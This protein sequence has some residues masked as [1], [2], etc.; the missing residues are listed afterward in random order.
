MFSKFWHREKD[1]IIPILLFLST[2]V[3]GIMSQYA[4]ASFLIYLFPIPLYFLMQRINIWQAIT[5]G[6]NYGLYFGFS[7]HLY[8]S[9][10]ERFDPF[11][12]ALLAYSLSFLLTFSGAHYLMRKYPKKEFVQ[13]FAFAF[14]WL[15]IQVALHYIPFF[16]PA[17]AF[18]KTTNT[19]SLFDWVMPYFGA[20]MVEFVI[21]SFGFLLGRLLD[22]YLRG[23]SLRPLFWYVVAFT[24]FIAIGLFQ[25]FTTPQKN[26]SQTVRVAA[27]QGNFGFEWSKRVELADD[28]LDYFISTTKEVAKKGAKVVV[29]PEYAAAVDILTERPDLSER[30]EKAS[31]D[32][33]V[34]IVM[35]SLERAQSEDETDNGI[36]YDLSLVYDPDKGRLEPYRAV[37]PYSSNIYHG[38]K[39]IIFKTKYGN[40]PVL[41]CFEIARHRFVADY[42]NKGEPIDFI[43]AIGN[44]QVFDGTYGITRLQ[45]HARRIAVEND[46]SLMYVTNTGPTTIYTNEGDTPTTVPFQT[47]GYV[48]Y[49]IEKKR[50]VALYS[51]FQDMIPL[52]ATSVV[53]GVA[54]F[55]TRIG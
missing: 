55:T 52:V 13:I 6:A 14:A 21:L 45:Q 32:L 8:L 9:K 16:G 11:L 36:G 30:V 22:I 44:N 29:W 28:I 15:V 34:V 23:K 51:R 2:I 4:G 18:V 37:Y 35:G 47:Q 10:F 5:Y 42:F 43:I 49:D 19:P 46:R 54:L 33:D 3:M 25:A 20:G 1:N 39:P 38:K 48:M 17:K 41:S 26:V 50:A 12:L 27:V 40:F 31:K 24:L 7:A 53:F